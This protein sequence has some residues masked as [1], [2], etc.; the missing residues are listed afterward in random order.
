[1]SGLRIYTGQVQVSSGTGVDIKDITGRLQEQVRESG[2]TTGTLHAACTGSTGSLT[3]IEYEPGVVA[4]LA[5]TINELAPPDREYEHE[6]AWHDGNGHSH[7]QAAL[8]GPGLVIPVRKGR[9]ALGT[10]Q[11]VVVINHDVKPRTRTV[12][13]TV[14][15]AAQ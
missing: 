7:V 6:K 11:Q 12:E 10:W 14:M 4:D 13:I 3:C 15:G 5:R 9:C 8:I 1:M 2:I